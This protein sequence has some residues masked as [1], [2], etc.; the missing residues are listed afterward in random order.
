MELTKNDTKMLQGLSVLAMVCL[1]LFC[2]SYEGL[3]E[4]LLFINDVPVCFCFA[5]LCD[6]CVFGLAFCSGYG[7]MSIYCKKNYY[8]KRLK[9]LLVLIV[10]F[11]VILFGATIVSVLLGYSDF[12]PGSARDFFGTM[13]FYEM[14]Y[15]G[16]WWYLW[17]YSLLVLISPLLLKAIN[18]FSAIFIVLISFSIYCL[19][20]Y[21]RFYSREYKY[22]YFLN[23]FG[24]FGT[25]LFEYVVG[26]VTAK[27]M[28]FTK[29][30]S[31]ENKVPSAAK[32]I[33][34]CS[35][36]LILFFAKTF[37]IPNVF[38]APFTGFIIITVFALWRKPKWV[39]NTFMFLGKHS[40]NIW[41]THMFFIVSSFVYIAKYPLP[42]F[43]FLMVI[44]IAI[45]FAVSFV[46]KG[47]TK[48]LN[49]VI[50]IQ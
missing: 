38:F 2:R 11:W 49:K 25:T 30:T 12:M 21:V 27:I 34:G 15:N 47:I 20:F 35:I 24:P 48:V 18:R 39:T 9:S 45:S 5:L 26:A 31:L 4:P 14:H 28:F 1:H 3:F 40:T 50:K 13:F 43:M 44:T 16:A 32:G 37:L 23:Y 36:I 46:M 22:D 41:L 19:A 42:I 33:I 8:K 29:I 17:A 10:N 6:F 7:H